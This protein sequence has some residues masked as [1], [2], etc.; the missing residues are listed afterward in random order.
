MSHDEAQPEIT[1]LLRESASGNAESRERV[2]A[3]LYAELHRQASHHRWRLSGGQTLNTTALLHET[4]LR[5]SGDSAPEYQDRVHF[6][7]VSGRVMRN[8]LVDHARRRLA[9]KRGGGVPDAELTDLDALPEVKDDEVVA[10]HEALARL[11]AMDARQARVVELRY[12]VGL[13]V[14]EVAEVLGISAATVKRDWAMARAW[15]QREI[16]SAR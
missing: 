3:L 16:E 4:F 6:F 1:R 11:E 9:A 7:R 2:V 12:F 15:L 13:E 5:L 10:V 14:P 8:V